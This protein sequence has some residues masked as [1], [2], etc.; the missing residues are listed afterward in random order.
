MT[1][2]TILTLG[3]MSHIRLQ[4]TLRNNNITKVF[5]AL[6]KDAATKKEV[7]VYPCKEDYSISA[8]STPFLCQLPAVRESADELQPGDVL[9]DVIL[10]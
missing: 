6:I 10:K 8:D 7:E 3:A 2:Y 9:T 5:S 1:T 4:A